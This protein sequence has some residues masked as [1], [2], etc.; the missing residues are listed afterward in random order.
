MKI[1][2]VNT[3]HQD[4][5]TQNPQLIDGEVKHWTVREELLRIGETFQQFLQR[6]KEKWEKYNVTAMYL[7]D[8]QPVSDIVGLPKKSAIIVRYYLEK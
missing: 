4:E 3:P 1:I 7:Y 5:H 2:F 6:K 8:I